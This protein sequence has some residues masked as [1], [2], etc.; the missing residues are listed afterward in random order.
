MKN[1]EK[2]INIYEWIL[3]DK[4]SILEHNDNNKT[5]K[6]IIR[7]NLDKNDLFN[8]DTEHYITLAHDKSSN[9]Y[10]VIFKGLTHLIKIDRFDDLKA[11]FFEKYYQQ[12]NESIL[13][14]TI[15][16]EIERLYTELNP[17]QLSDSLFGNSAFDVANF[18]E[19]LT[20][21]T[22]AQE[23]R[24]QRRRE[25]LMREEAMRARTLWNDNPTRHMPSMFES[26]DEHTVDRLRRLFPL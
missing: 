24:E 19:E 13:N 22:R 17:V 11:K 26:N 4:S 10:Y 16:D 5:N 21:I 18:N 1:L 7:F 14:N 12:Q 8:E 15:I 25:E 2:L 6:F 9:I 3:D 23:E 20:R